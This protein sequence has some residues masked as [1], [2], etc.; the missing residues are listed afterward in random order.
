MDDKQFSG[1]GVVIKIKSNLLNIKRLD[2]REKLKQLTFCYTT[3][4][5][6]GSLEYSVET[7]SNI[8]L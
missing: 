3:L 2:K 1:R 8:H 6:D 7:I 5:K 4:L